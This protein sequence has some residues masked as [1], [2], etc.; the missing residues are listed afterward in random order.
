MR[1]RRIA[2]AAVLICLVA[3]AV[4]FVPP[5]WRALVARRTVLAA[6]RLQGLHF[7]DAQRELI[8]KNVAQDREGYEKLRAVPLANSVAPA[9]LFRP[10]PRGW[11]IE[12]G[13]SAVALTPHPGLRAPK[14]LQ[15]LAFASI[16]ELSELLRTRQ[17]TSEAL[18]RQSL[19]RLKSLDPKLLAVVTLLE[20]RALAEAQKADAEL[21]AGHWR[22][23][24]HGIPYGAKDLL[25]ARGGP[26]TWGSAAHKEQRFD[27]DATAIARLSQAGAVLVA[28][29]SLG[30]LA[31]GDVWFGGKTKNPWNTQRGSSGSSAGPAAAVA[32]GLVPFALGSETL[33][34][35]VSPATECGVTGLRPTFGR[36]SRA[37]AMALSWSMDKI[38]P[39]CR[40]AEDCAVVLDAIRGADGL[41]ATVVDAPLRFAP[42]ADLRGVKLGVLRAAFDEKRPAQENDERALQQLRALGAELVPFEAP[43]LPLREMRLILVSEAA[44]AFEELTRSGRDSL[45]ARQ[46]EDAWPVILRRAKLIPAVEY[47]NANRVRALL[48]EEM[49]KR[50][51]GLDALISPTHGAT[52]LTNL[53]GHPAVV[54][55]DGFT[56]EGV[57][58][59]L[60]FIGQLLREGEVL[61]IAGAWQEATG[62]HHRHPPLATARALSEREPAASPPS[63]P[64][65]AGSAP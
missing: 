56:K 46:G 12:Q 54:V 49:D 17:V 41:D 8:A 35:I 61:A 20:E 31:M 59:S 4:W 11:R 14:D 53:T 34:S 6:E 23:P 44:A 18:T 51:R 55:P 27:E 38:G 9:L 10:W 65:R 16:T 64:A 39:L 32:A 58:T 28:K 26:T 2:A 15:Q 57:P 45:L 48:I 13:P 22:G 24:L 37:G 62:F 3:A 63:P 42:R 1:A 40:S 25:A 47:V 21:A 5:R 43:A 33:G 60:T 36:V 30:E 7:S 19:S 52:M 50:M 29:L